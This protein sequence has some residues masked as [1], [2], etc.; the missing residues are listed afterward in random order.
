MGSASLQ[1]EKPSRM[2]WANGFLRNLS[3]L[4]T[5]VSA[6]GWFEGWSNDHLWERV[7][8]PANLF[9]TGYRA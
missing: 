9:Q 6:P 2:V 4:Y 5:R 8:H 7:K 3:S 1:E